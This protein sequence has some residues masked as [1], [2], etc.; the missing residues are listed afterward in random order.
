MGGSG[1]MEASPGGPSASGGPSGSSGSSGRYLLRHDVIP[2]RA[3]ETNAVQQHEEAS[4]PNRVLG[5]R[6]THGEESKK[7]ARTNRGRKRWFNLPCAVNQ[8]A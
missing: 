2:Q 7:C 5:A 6:R 8:R 4:Q 3:S 1:W